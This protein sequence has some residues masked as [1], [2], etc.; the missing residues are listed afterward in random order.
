MADFSA[1]ATDMN[2]KIVPGATLVEPVSR[3]NEIA[4]LGTIGQGLSQVGGIIG[5]YMKGQKVAGDAKVL[6]EYSIKLNTIAD[7]LDQGSITASAAQIQRRAL[8]SQY[9]ANY[10]NLGDDLLKRTSAFRESNGFGSLV[11][12]GIM[13]A[14]IEQETIKG[15]VNNGF[16]ST[17]DMNNPTA[18]DNAIKA[19]ENFLTIQR[20]NKERMDVLAQRKSVLEVGSAERRAVEEEQKTAAITGLTKQAAASIPMIDAAIKNIETA[21]NG[22]FSAE[23]RNKIITEGF[24]EIEKTF[25]QTRQEIAVA[26]QG[27]L[28]DAQIDVALGPQKS[29]I[30]LN[31]KRLSGELDAESYEKQ[32]KVVLERSKFMAAQSINGD[33]EAMMWVGA[34]EVFKSAAAAGAF[35]ENINNVVASAITKAKTNAKAATDG[36]SKPANLFVAD[37]D[38]VEK[39]SVKNYLDVVKISVKDYNNPRSIADKEKL[40]AEIDAQINSVLTGIQKHSS[41]IDSASEMQPIID[42]FADSDVMMFM[43]GKGI[44]AYGAEQVKPIIQQTYEQQVVPA[45]QSALE[46]EYAKNVIGTNTP[47]GE[48]TIKVSDIATP[49]FQNGV[50]MYEHVSG[51]DATAQER[52]AIEALNNSDAVK[53]ANKLISAEASLSG[54]ADKQKAWDDVYKYILAPEQGDM[55][56]EGTDVVVEGGEDVDLEELAVSEDDDVLDEVETAR[57]ERMNDP[58]WMSQ[59]TQAAQMMQASLQSDTASE[60]ETT[61]PKGLAGITASNKRGYNPDISNIR[62]EVLSGLSQLQQ[63]FGKK[64]PIVSGFRDRN[65]NAKAGGAK[66]SQHIHGNALDL[67]V[68]HLNREERIQLIK[69]A[70]Q[71]GW[72][73]VGIYNN[74]IH[75]DKG[76]K[77]AWGANYRSTSLPR[78]AAAALN[79]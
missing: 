49:T 15:A 57:Q 7:A 20:E 42:F 72:G 34:S 2:T 47:L 35:S 41:S 58:E 24:F 23:E 32:T 62:P 51:M 59:A 75:L 43:K 40:Q 67:D 14:Q 55:G 53:V 38:E 12:P 74:S 50:F 63:S 22:A 61:R 69:M 9:L 79:S 33:Q 1:R 27:M 6:S 39:K 28:T 5:G 26:S 18:V 60:I 45:I 71:Q 70:R 56:D 21:L 8:E 31:K 44:G 17:A 77:R 36:T 54:S 29:L 76:P 10:P 65:R 52:A 48:A 66:G 4:A 37:G 25:T 3:Q 13:A 46:V 78:W 68:S 73:G 30:E 11:S 16:L 19:Q 64:L